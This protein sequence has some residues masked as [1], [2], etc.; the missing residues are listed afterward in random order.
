MHVPAEV[1]ADSLEFMH[2]V[3]IEISPAHACRSGT[4]E[5]DNGRA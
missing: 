1:T 4:T 5:H 3:V 2:V